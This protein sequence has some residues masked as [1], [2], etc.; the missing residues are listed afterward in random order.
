MPHHA[1]DDHQHRAALL[2]QL[3]LELAARSPRKLKP[4]RLVRLLRQEQPELFEAFVADVAIED[5]AAQ[6]RFLYKK[7][8]HRKQWPRLELEE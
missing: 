8:V 6:M 1:T 5:E 2:R 3:P 7:L 4:R